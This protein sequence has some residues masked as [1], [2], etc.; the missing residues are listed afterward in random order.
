MTL[1][2][3]MMQGVEHAV[4][5]YLGIE[6]LR[7][8]SALRDLSLPQNDN[9]AGIVHQAISANWVAGQASKNK[10]VS[11]QNWR[12]CLQPQIGRAN[13]SPEVT[14]ER[15]VAAAC[16]RMGREDWANQIPV[17]SGLIAGRSEGRRAVDLAQHHGGPHYELIELKVGSDTPLYAVVELLAYASLWLLARADPPTLVPLLLTGTH[18]DLRVLAPA[19]FY[20][21]FEL[22]ALEAAVERGVRSLGDAEGVKLTFAFDVLPEV[23]TVRPLPDD[24]MLLSALKD[25]RR[26]HG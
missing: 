3:S 17:C 23:L 15:A 20:V 11:R 6:N 19:A 24:S 22:L 1:P 8:R 4:C 26:L 9:I 5:N 14:L 21:G 12:W 25:R 2:T 16:D 18:V 7:H 10:N 13:R